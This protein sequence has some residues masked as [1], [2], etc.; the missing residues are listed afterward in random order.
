MAE[1]RRLALGDAGDAAALAAELRA[2]VPGGDDVSEAVSAIVARVRTGGD[3]SP[4]P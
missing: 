1:L 4:L 3:A 2:A